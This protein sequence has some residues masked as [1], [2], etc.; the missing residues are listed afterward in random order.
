MTST[1]RVVLRTATSVR[2]RIR[3]LKQLNSY[4]T[5]L[6]QNRPLIT[7]LT[8]A[9]PCAS[10][11]QQKHGSYNPLF[12]DQILGTMLTKYNHRI[13]VKLAGVLNES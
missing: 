3:P 5:A 8:D 12:T 2:D 10:E 6:P 9:I 11:A 13:M 7:R 1:P 4:I